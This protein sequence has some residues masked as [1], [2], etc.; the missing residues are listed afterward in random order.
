MDMENLSEEALQRAIAQ[1]RFVYAATIAERLDY[2][3]EKLRQLRELA[4]RQMACEYRNAAATRCLVRE[5]GFSRTDLE[6]LL[7]TAVDELESSSG[8]IR[9]ERCYDSA[10]GKYLTLREWVDH[11]L[12]AKRK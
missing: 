6:D 8:K 2:P 7:V 1:R 4:I 10:S 5:W 9:S 11:F 3:K 12:G